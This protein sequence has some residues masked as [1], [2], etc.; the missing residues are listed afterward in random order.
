VKHDWSKPIDP[1]KTTQRLRLVLEHLVRA[2]ESTKHN[3]SLER[4]RE[5]FD[6]VDRGLL[7][8][9]EFIRKAG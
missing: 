9:R 2:V 7:A 4:T 5:I 1:I 6:Y 8:C 3:T